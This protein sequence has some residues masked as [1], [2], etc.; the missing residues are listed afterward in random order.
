MDFLMTEAPSLEEFEAWVLTKNAG[1][2][3]PARVARL[4]SALRGDGKFALES[5]LPEPVL[6]DEGLAFLG[7]TRL[8]PGQAGCRPRLMPGR[9]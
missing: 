1:A 7:R 8:H 5:I 4:N 6:S 3:D 9:G 2:I